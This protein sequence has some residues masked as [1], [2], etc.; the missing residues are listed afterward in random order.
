M[1]ISDVSQFLCDSIVTFV[2][3]TYTEPVADA[4]VAD[5]LQCN[6]TVIIGGTNTGLATEWSGPGIDGSNMFDPN[7]EVDQEGW[8]ILTVTSID[9]CTDVDSV[10]VVPD[11]DIPSVNPTVSD[12]L[13]CI[14]NTVELSS[15]VT[16]PNVLVEWSGPGI[17]GSNRNLNSFDVSIE[18][19]YYLFATDTVNGCV[20]AIDSVVVSDISYNVIALISNL[21]TLDCYTSNF[22]LD[23]S[24][25]FG[26]DIIYIW[27]V[28]DSVMTTDTS[29]MLSVS[30]GGQYVLTVI[31]TVS[32]C[33]GA[34]TV[35]VVD[36]TEY[37]PANAGPDDSL[38]CEILQTSLTALGL[39]GLLN[40][41][42][43][44]DG[45]GILGDST[46]PTI[47]VD[48]PGIYTLTVTDTSNGC[49]RT[50]IVEVVRIDELPMVEAGE[51]DSIFCADQVVIISAEGSDTGPEYDYVWT[52]PTGT[53]D[54][55]EFETGTPGA[56]T[57]I[58][59]NNITG[60]Q[61]TDVVI[62][63]AGEFLDAI[64]MIETPACFGDASGVIDL[65]NVTGGQGPY[66]YGID[67]FAFQDSPIFENVGS[68]Q[69]GVYVQDMNGCQWASSVV[70]PEGPVIDV[71]VG[72][73]IHLQLGDTIQ[74]DAIIYPGIEFIDSIV[75]DPS[76]YLS[77]RTCP[78]PVLTA[79]TNQTITATIY[80]GQ[81][82]EDSD[83]LRLS[84]DKRVD[85][86]VPNVF[87]PNGDGVNDEVT[88]YASDVVELIT[89]FEIFDRWGEKVFHNS[90]FE[91]N[92]ESEGWDGTFRGEMMQPAVFAYRVRAR[93]ID[94]R[95]LDFSGD[96]TL[97]R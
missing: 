13:S 18:G 38:T 36:L 56:Y 84:V 42:V 9:G 23:G 1:T 16:N 67:G 68:G 55:F 62:I 89:E 17:D 2:V 72:Q 49:D 5:T 77:C 33:L 51:N 28:E 63:G 10:E 48:Q 14:V 69:Y 88:V 59:T 39:E 27:T 53:I 79:I 95:E 25:S 57:L 3:T 20:S 26:S 87:S 73:D 82:C 61:D 50:D 96:I 70:V 37:P 94:G 58:V 21:D 15:G 75:W 91:P 8:Y 76:E 22:S 31:D 24:G 86:Y 65:S 4:G 46:N 54:A 83:Q 78:D 34:D 40:I 60:C 90:N 19:T 6:G 47:L 52:G 44:W 32:G 66:M 81:E 7:P 93:L 35:E 30:V 64:P 11:E 97:V 80:A 29:T 74:L 92:L 41:R 12:S 43:D 45:P 85:I 71:Q